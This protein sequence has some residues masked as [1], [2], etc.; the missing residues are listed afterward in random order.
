MKKRFTKITSLFLVAT[1]MTG[2]LAG[3]SGGKDDAGS[4]G[5]AAGS[6]TSKE[7][8]LVY[9]Y[10]GT[11][12]NDLEAVN[13][14]VNK[15][16]KE[17]INATV[18]LKLIDWAAYDQQM[19]LVMSS[20]EEYDLCY[21]ASNTNSYNQ[22]VAKGAFLDMTEL[23]DE[24][25]PETKAGVPQRF[26]DA[27]TING[28]IYGAVNFQ[29]AAA[30]F[31]FRMQSELADKYN[32]DWKSTKELK[33]LTP[34]LEQVKKNE[35]DLIPFG[36]NKLVDPFTKGPVAWGFDAIG[37]LSSP[38]WVKMDDPDYKVVNQYESEEFKEYCDLMRSWYEKG[39]MRSDVATMTDTLPD[40]QAGKYA[41]EYEQIDI[42]T[43][44]FEEVGLDFQGRMYNLSG[45]ESYDHKFV[46]PILTTEKATATMTA[47][48]STSKNP[49]RAMMFIELLN[50]D[51]ELYN[52]L[53]Y[54]IEGKHY[55]HV[56]DEMIEV[57]L[58]AGYKTDTAWEFGNMKNAFLTVGSW[59][60]G[61]DELREDGLTK[62]TGLWYDLNT[63]V[64]GS[65][66]L[67]FTFD[68]EPVKSQIA[69]CQTVIDQLYTSISTGSVD[70]DTY[71]PQFNEQLKAAGMD[72][73]IAEKQAQLD[74]WL[75]SK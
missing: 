30:G 11:P 52:L 37:D 16:T 45:K 47:I 32:F 35:P 66:L 65:P 62:A 72:E 25:A 42:G 17:K 15:I 73:I 46:E 28:K 40:Q 61:G 12:Q 63:N 26:W 59:P 34:F 64:E 33:D 68:Y 2:V 36:Y 51:K 58:E 31:G 53:T 71:I 57:D 70:P 41:V 67:G 49:E 75:A 24:Y 20:G 7:V 8:N 39:Y 55:K 50:T 74:E 6:D 4:S 19:A 44:D 1:M 13:E 14:A 29:Q 10:V 69:N 60:E 48:S 43:E 22:N 9:Y 54:G 38:G 5:E 18:E 56:S 27:A 21:T 3:C 23:L